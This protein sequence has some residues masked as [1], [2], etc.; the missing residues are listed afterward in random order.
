VIALYIPTL[1]RKHV[2]RRVVDNIHEATT[3][4]H[5]IIFVCENH[6]QD[7][8][9]EARKWGDR[10][11]VN[12][13]EP[14]Y[15]NSLQ[16]AYE[17]D[18]APFFIG[19]NDDFDFKP[20]WDVEAMKVMETPGV[21][22]VGI[23]DGNPSCNFST[24][25]LIDRSYI[26]VHS[27]VVDMPN[28]VNF[29][30]RHNYVDTEFYCTAVSRGVFAPAPKSQIF[31]MHPDFGHGRFDKTYMKSRASFSDDAQTFESRRHLWTG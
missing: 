23:F 7:S 24:I 22:V 26:E 17:A 3:L 31:H 10:T 14:S 18:D 6:D 12:H 28:R 2:L 16:T 11:L 1:G 20:G 25:S 27:G 4:P 13:E 5:R 8:I 9:D 29:T 30:Y 15:S 21:Q 19:A